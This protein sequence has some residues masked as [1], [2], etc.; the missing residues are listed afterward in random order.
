MS[1]GFNLRQGALLLA[2][3]AL[4][5]VGGEA[6][7]IE[8]SIPFSFSVNDATL[9]PGSYVLSSNVPGPGVVVVRGATRAI[10]AMTSPRGT[11]EDYQPRLVFHRY[12]DDYFLRQVWTDGGT[13]YDLRETRGER[14]RRE[15]RSGRAATQGERV[16]VPVL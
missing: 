4:V 15:G 3:L 8:A 10:I 5:P 16:V 12:G 11:S 2:L 7:G 13:G 14:D 1:G 6:A 9:P